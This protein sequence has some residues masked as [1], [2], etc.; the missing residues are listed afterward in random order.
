MDVIELTKKLISFPSVTPEDAGCLDY[1][2]QLLKSNG[3]TVERFQF[4]EVTNLYAKKGSGKNL[5]FAGHTDVVPPGDLSKWTSPPFEPE[6]RDGVL[7][8]RGA[9]D[10]KAA[11]A[12]SIVAA[13]EYKGVG[14]V[15]LLLT[16][17]EEGPGVNGTKRVLE[18]LEKRGEKIDGCIVGE[19]TNVEKLGD[20]A[21]IGRRGSM[22][23]KI[24]VNGKQGHAAYPH[25][26]DNPVKKLINILHELQ[27][28]K[29]DNGNEFFQPSNLEVVTFDVG[30]PASNVI[31]AKATASFNIR[32]NNIHTSDS[33]KIWIET[34]TDDA[35]LEFRVSGE[36][37]ITKP[38]KLSQVVVD[39]VKQ[40]TGLKPEL[41]TT[42]GTS[43]ARFIANYSEVVEFGM[44]NKSAHHIDENAKIDEIIQLK[45]VYSKI[46]QKFFA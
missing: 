34:V 20:M 19:P 8:G 39:A 30:N 3:F 35:E 2:E 11:V 37:F 18:E 4:H 12:A 31:P 33:L 28:H 6:I 42:G 9:A 15:S 32:F 13:L 36:S 40:V 10:M 21:K 7:Y 29:L 23:C 27:N 38:A 17:D 24:T 43:D 44:I 41:S 26:A 14:A 25:L 16:A 45:E 46:L 22:N 1:V 5:C